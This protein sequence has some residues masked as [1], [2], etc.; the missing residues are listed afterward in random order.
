[1]IKSYKE[2]LSDGYTLSKINEELDNKKLYKLE[3][4]F[5]SDTKDVS[6]VDLISVKYPNAVITLETALSVYFDD[7]KESN[8]IEIVTSH[9]SKKLKDENIKQ[10]FSTSPGFESGIVSYK[11]LNKIYN[12]E[13]LLIEFL[14]HKEL[15]DEDKFNNIISYFIKNKDKLSKEKV[16][17]YLEDF[18]HNDKMY[19]YIENNIFQKKYKEAKKM[20]GIVLAGGSGTR[21]S[22]ITLATSKQLLA[23]YDKPMVYYPISV[24]MLAGIKDILI[25]TTPQDQENF[26]RLLGDGSQFGVNF[27]YV[28]QPSPDG[29]AQAFLLGEEFIG[30]D[31]CALALGDNIF[32]GNGFVKMLEN[33]VA[34]CQKG[35]ATNFGIR[36]HDPERFGVMEVEKIGDQNFKILSIEEKPKKPKSNYAVTGLYFYPNDVVKKAKEVK[37]S[38]RGELEITTLNNLYL[39]EQRLLGELLGGGFNWYDTGTFD[40][41]LDASL[42]I[43]QI[44]QNSDRVIAC[45]E[46]IAYDNGWISKEELKTYVRKFGT[47]NSY[48]Q[49][50]DNNAKKGN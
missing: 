38:E 48:G 6:K 10:Y 2:L 17:T 33:A 44:Q 12:L 13:K 28:V 39:E 43:K 8:V 9:K 37:P 23:I 35:F 47:K 24:L 4:G 45:L 40:S 27:S 36:V 29:L 46:Q 42:S 19:Y 22:P 25:I 34:N 14:R 5:Y 20:K 1:M 3:K 31:S 30:N 21:L 50:L 49:Y 41:L 7:Y 26:K 16:F 11:S 15:Y 32:Y 18:K